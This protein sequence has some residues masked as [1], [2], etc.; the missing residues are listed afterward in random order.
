MRA[1]VSQRLGLRLRIRAEPG[2]NQAILHRMARGTEVSIIGGPVCADGYQWWN[3][4]LGARG[5]GW[6]AEGE[7]QLYYLEPLRQ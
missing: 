6:V 4:D 1:V 7:P 5:T 2:L 3:I